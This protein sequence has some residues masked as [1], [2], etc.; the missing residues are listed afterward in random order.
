LSVTG[1]SARFNVTALTPLVAD[2][3]ARSTARFGGH[4]PA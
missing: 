2:A 4:S 3:A 1:A